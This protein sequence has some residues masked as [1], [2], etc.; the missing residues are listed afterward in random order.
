MTRSVTVDTSVT[1]TRRWSRLM[2][3]R[4]S[5]T[6]SAAAGEIE[7]ML[8]ESVRLLR[9]LERCWSRFRPESDI[10]R[11]NRAGGQAVDVDASTVVLLREM[12]NAAQVTDG[13][14]DP[15]LL[16]AIVGL[17]YGPAW[18]NG[19]ECGSQAAAGVGI[20]RR[21]GWVDDTMIDVDGSRVCLPPGVQ[22]DPGAI[23]K[24]LA[25][26][27]VAAEIY[28][29]GAAAVRVVVGGDV[30]SSA[31]TIVGIGAPDGSGRIID[32]IS[33]AAGG[34]ATSG[35]GR[36]WASPGGDIVH[37]VLD[38]RTRRSVAHRGPLEIVQ[39][40]VAAATGA[41]A[42]AWATASLVDGP[43]IVAER[44]DQR[45]V[46]ALAV[47]RDGSMFPNSEWRSLQIGLD[48]TEG[49]RQAAAV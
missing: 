19:P 40:S 15:T 43:A 49:H 44:L 20:D 26:D 22:L 14:F 3:C 25:A 33:I 39:V 5:V 13:A 45:G 35:T 21:A 46:A 1:V 34:V 42:E 18:S 23:G 29:V 16:G 4:G 9:H 48:P 8:A 41:S 24:G 6:V 37:H 27:I 2:G 10:S 30:R 17:G 38:P 7:A 47:G 36:R 12:A 32:R 11:L 28:G 31:P